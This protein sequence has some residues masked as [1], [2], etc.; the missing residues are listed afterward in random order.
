MLSDLTQHAKN[1]ESWWDYK[2]YA[3]DISAAKVSPLATA[4]RPRNVNIAPTD[5]LLFL[6][7][8]ADNICVYSIADQSCKRDIVLT[9]S[10]L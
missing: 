7:R 5:D 2:L 9:A 8:D 10:E 1:D 6:R 3:L 4:F